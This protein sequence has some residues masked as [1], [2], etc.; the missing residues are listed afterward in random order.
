[1]RNSSFVIEFL[2]HPKQIGTF[3][4]SSKHL[5][6]QV[7]KEIDGSNEVVEFGAGAGYVTREILK[8]LPDN[9]RLI[10]FEISPKF[11]ENLEKINDSRLRVINNDAK[12][13]KRYIDNLKCIVSGLPL[14]LFAKPKREKILDITSKSKRYVQLQYTPLLTKK[15]KNYFPDV[16]MKFV[17]QNFPPAFIHVCRSFVR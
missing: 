2:K 10:C 8:R 7:A 11:C 16:K 3:T 4:Q 12:N 9:G 13:C 5:A 1:M 6:K 14:T 17:P 15:M